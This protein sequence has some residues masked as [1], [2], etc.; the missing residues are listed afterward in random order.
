MHPA[1]PISSSCHS[2]FQPFSRSANGLRHSTTGRSGSPV[3]ARTSFSAPP[4]HR[5][6]SRAIVIFRGPCRSGPTVVSSVMGSAEVP[7]VT[8]MPRSP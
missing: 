1:T 4:S 5:S 2:G 7:Y 3:N 8:P 6:S